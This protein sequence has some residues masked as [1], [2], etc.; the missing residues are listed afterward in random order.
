MI[1][2]SN[3]TDV[4]VIHV[5]DLI[6]QAPFPIELSNSE[7]VGE[8]I[9]ALGS[10]SGLNNVASQGYITSEDKSF[11]IGSYVYEDLYQISSPVSDGNSG[12]P[13]VAKQSE[14]I[15]A[16]NSAKSG[17]DATIGF[18][19]PLYKVISLIQSWIEWPM[20]EKSICA[21]RNII[22][23]EFSDDNED[24]FDYNLTHKEWI[25]KNN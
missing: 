12:G 6:G 23:S 22:D 5:P 19:I 9:V 2:Y 24:L 8:K 11:N 21:Q 4:A 7:M 3:D 20:S 14:K 15:I 10:P 1:G 25:D 18:S 16:I 17:M 13:L